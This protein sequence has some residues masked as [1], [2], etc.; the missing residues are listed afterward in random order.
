MK[1]N[2]NFMEEM[3]RKTAHLDKEFDRE[4]P[5]RNIDKEKLDFI[6]QI[7]QH[8]KKEIAPKPEDYTLWKRILKTLGF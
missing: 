5:D 1:N 2:P 6:N 7:K 3:M 4:F 8:K